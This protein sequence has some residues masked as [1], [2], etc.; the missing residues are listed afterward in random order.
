MF[1]G[2]FVLFLYSTYFGLGVKLV[3]R[4]SSLLPQAHTYVSR[5]F[6]HIFHGIWGKGK[7]CNSSGLRGV[8]HRNQDLTLEWCQMYAIATEYR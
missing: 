1:V 4:Y 6:V 2:F 7:W 5:G 8:S 3:T